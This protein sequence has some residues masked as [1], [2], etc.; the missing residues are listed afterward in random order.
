MPVIGEARGD[1]LCVRDVSGGCLAAIKCD[2]PALSASSY[3]A[4]LVTGFL[5]TTALN[6]SGYYLAR[7]VMRNPPWEP[8]INTTFFLESQ[9]Q[10]ER[11]LSLA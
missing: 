1:K 4:M 9:G 10:K 5:A 7:W 8:P 11:K 3:L 6:F 2:Q